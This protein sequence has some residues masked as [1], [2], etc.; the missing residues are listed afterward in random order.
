MLNNFKNSC[1]YLIASMRELSMIQILLLIP[2]LILLPIALPII[3][4]TQFKTKMDF[5]NIKAECRKE[6]NKNLPLIKD[7][8][9]LEE[10]PLVYDDIEYLGYAG[11][12]LCGDSDN[13]N[14]TLDY[15][16]TY[17]TNIIHNGRTEDDGF[18]YL[19]L[20]YSSNIYNSIANNRFLFRLSLA[21]TLAHELTHYKQFMANHRFDGMKN[22][23]R[24]DE[25]LGLYLKQPIEKEA[26]S[27]AFKY[28]CKYLFTIMK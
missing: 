28:V 23:V 4:L 2:Q 22:Y 20:I 26:R 21:N 18:K 19:L 10:L 17:N 9:G 16:N 8:L 13:I 24:A 1:K 14:G 11:M 15:I 5:D 7:F 27:M 12:F 6:V 25:C 3:K